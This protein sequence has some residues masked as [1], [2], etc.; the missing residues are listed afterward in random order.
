MRR[1]AAIASILGVG[2]LSGAAARAAPAPRVVLVPVQPATI[3]EWR[4]HPALRDLMRDGSVA[5]L[6]TLT[7][8]RSK[9]EPRTVEAGFR[10]LGAGARRDAVGDGKDLARLLA[11]EHVPFGV[12]PFLVE[13]I[14]GTPVRFVAGV[15]SSASGVVF[16]DALG[17]QQVDEGLRSIERALDDGDILIVFSPIATPERRR[18]AIALGVIAIR[19]HGFGPGT[20]ASP[21]TRRA[22]VVTLTDIA[23][24][25]LSMHG[26]DA[27]M[28]GRP[29]SFVGRKDA[30]DA[31]ANLEMDAVASTRARR[32]LTRGMLAVASAVMLVGLGVRATGRRVEP[33]LLIVVAAIPVSLYLVGIFGLHGTASMAV[34]AGAVALLLGMGT[35]IMLGADSAM[36]VV[37]GFT[38]VVPLVDLLAGSPLAIRS[39]LTFQ[40]AGGGRFYGV[41][42]EVLG[43]I[44][45]AILFAAASLL[46]RLPRHHWRW[47]AL[48]FAVVVFVVSAPALGAKFGAPLTLVPAMGVFAVLAA[49]RRLDAKAIFAI[50][51]ATILTTGAFIAADALRSPE[52]RSHVARATVEGR[53]VAGVLARK[54]HAGWHVLATTAWTPALLAFA[55]TA[56]LALR[57]RT[58]GDTLYRAGCVA[59]AVAAVAGLLLN[60]DGVI[61][62]T[63]IAMFAAI[64]ALESA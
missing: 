58:A 39:P 49:G 8:E 57:Y 35:R 37:L 54:W 51:A 55:A 28:D 40:I 29:I 18:S 34:A 7:A 47:V 20:L 32:P 5:L 60:D 59:F 36:L 43:V 23:P 61:T 64:M 46:R 25:V 12:P 33:A 10:T 48:S 9:D 2:L 53:S 63:M 3:A 4:A 11:R 50:A 21:S 16:T 62:A 31:V 1:F 22:G 26:I 15:S 19:G 13:A 6:S 56:I 27:A 42:V 24:T 52:A 41:G 45:G 30:A 44:A 17:S 38:V 14:G